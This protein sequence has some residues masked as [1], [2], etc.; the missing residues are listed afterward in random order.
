MTVRATPKLAL[1]LNTSFVKRDVRWFPDGLSSNAFLLNVSRGSGSFFKGPG[2]SD[3]TA[4]CTLNDSIFTVINTTATNHFITGGTATYTPVDPLSIRLAAGYDYNTADVTDITPFGHL[5]V[6]L[7][8]IAE[9][10]WSRALITFDLAATYKKSLGRIF[11]TASSVGGQAF[12]SRLH[13]TDLSSSNFS[14][15]GVPTLT[16]GSIRN[17]GGVNEQRVI[18]AGFFGQEVVGWRDVLFVTGGLRVDGNS[19]F[20]TGF[21]LQKYPKLAVAYSISDE[22]FWSPRWIE[23]L[24]LRA[25]NG[26]SGKA[27]GAFDAVRTWDPV[28]AEG[29]LAAFEPSQVGNPN[30]GPERTREIEGGFDASML[31]GRLSASFSYYT[32]RTNGALVPVVKPPSLGFGARQLENIGVLKNQGSEVSL[33]A[34]LLTRDKVSIEAGV[35]YTRVKSEAGD[36]GGQTITVDANSLS[37]V[38]QGYS[39]PSY[40]GARITNPDA[41]ADP[42]IERNVFLG[43][44]FPTSIITPRAQMRL[45]NRVSVDAIGEFQRGG[46]LLNSIGFA[47]EGLFSWQPCYATQAKLRLATA[48]NTSALSDVTALE[49]GRCATAAASRDA[50][51]WVEKN[52]FFK[53]RSVSF[54]VDLPNRLIGSSNSSS[55]TFSGRNLFKSTSYTGTDPESA[56]QGVSTFARRDYYIFPSPR[57]FLVTLHTSF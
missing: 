4:I 33:N 49:R 3:T 57:S 35:Q 14:A 13:T 17:I 45:F 39:A 55:I 44:T 53:L 43:G 32:S 22:P 51:F 52:D 8:S 20:G 23:T 10:Q 31:N 1:A 2:C 24:K 9:T 46:H 50:S 34:Q 28:A 25:A 54:T 26:E 29:G 36:V 30:L 5:R 11:T 18:N 7:G 12:D 40:F 19:A 42:V 56:D 41:F 48:G 38:Q 15:P 47:N 21:G 6:P 37:F 16:S 27:P